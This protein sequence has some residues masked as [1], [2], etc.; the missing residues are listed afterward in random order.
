MDFSLYLDISGLYIRF[1]QLKMSE[2]IKKQLEEYLTEL[3]IRRIETEYAMNQRND[4][5]SNI[6]EKR[7]DLNINT[8]S[9]YAIG[10]DPVQKKA[11]EDINDK[12]HQTTLELARFDHERN[13]KLEQEKRAK[14]NQKKTIQL[15]YFDGILLDHEKQSI[16]V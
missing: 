15:C 12:I 3:E 4:K 1:N 9:K 8:Y 5:S 2:K 7:I 13:I 6:F 11:L 16:Q 14:L 10:I